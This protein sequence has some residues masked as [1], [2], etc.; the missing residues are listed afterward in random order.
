LLLFL[1]LLCVMAGNW[2]AHFYGMMPSGWQKWALVAGSVVVL[3]LGVQ[4]AWNSVEFKD[5]ILRQPLMDDAT[6]HEVVFSER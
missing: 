1:P 3:A 5:N 6:K 4:A 2:L